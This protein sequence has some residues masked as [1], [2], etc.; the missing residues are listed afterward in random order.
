[1]SD[2]VTS[3]GDALVYCHHR[4][5]VLVELANQRPPGGLMVVTA[6]V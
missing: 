3:S 6:I 5:D 4:E 2:C 1:M